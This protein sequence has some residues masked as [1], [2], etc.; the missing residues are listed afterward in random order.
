MSDLDKKLFDKKGNLKEGAVEKHFQDMTDDFN[1]QI[2]I[3]KDFLKAT[4]PKGRKPNAKG[5]RVSYTKGDLAH[6]LGV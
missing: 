2:E 3:R 1:R 4:P 5:G 6:V